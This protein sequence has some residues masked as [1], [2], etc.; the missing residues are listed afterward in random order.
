M[1]AESPETMDKKTY[2]GKIISLFVKNDYPEKTKMRFWSYLVG[3]NHREEKDGAL[4][5][6]YLE[7]LRHPGKCD[8]DKELRTWRTRSGVEQKPKTH[9]LRFFFPVASAILLLV[10]TSLAISLHLK[11]RPEIDLVQQHTPHAQMGSI[12]LPDGTQVQINAGSTLLY[13]EQFGKHGRSVFLIGQAGFKV[14]PDKKRPFVVKTDGFQVTALG[15]EFDVAAYPENPEI[16]TVLLE[17]SVRVDFDNLEKSVILRPNEQ[18]IYNRENRR[19]NLRMPDMKDITAWR[20]GELVFR[21]MT[22]AEILTT[23]ERRFDVSFSYRLRDLGTDRYSFRFKE[24][25]TL[26]EVMEVVTDVCGNLQFKIDGDICTLS[27]K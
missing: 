10:S 7:S 12:T 25:A 13:P 15:T 27:K 3:E 8:I 17:G 26:P 24:D 5:E 1:Y 2:A 4:E 21:Q 9:R 19:A 18:L 6:L 16:S 22:I 14:H 23:L 20:R 11:D